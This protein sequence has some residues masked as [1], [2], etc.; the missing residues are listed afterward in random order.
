M[1]WIRSEEEVDALIEEMLKKGKGDYVTQGVAFNK[2]SPRQME[3]LKKTLM[4]S[5]SFGGYVKDMLAFKF[6]E[7][8]LP[9]QEVSTPPIPVNTN[10]KER[11]KF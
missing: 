1:G 7:V 4:S 10:D 2:S 9:S 8:K 3:L 5:S 11:Y 6:S